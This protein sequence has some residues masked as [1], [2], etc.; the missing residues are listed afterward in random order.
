MNINLEAAVKRIMLHGPDRVIINQ[1]GEAVDSRRAREE[2]GLRPA[3]VF[4]RND[5]WSLGASSDLEQ[6]AFQQWPREWIGFMRRP[7]ETAKPMT[8]YSP[9]Q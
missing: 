8:E 6:V 2:H 9:P 1:E 5:G 7:A 3:I 4:I